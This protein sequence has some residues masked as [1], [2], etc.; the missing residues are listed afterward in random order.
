M[1]KGILYCLLYGLSLGVSGS[2]IHEQGHDTAIELSLL[3]TALFTTLFF[4]VVDYRNCVKNHKV[5]YSH[6][7]PWAVMSLTIVTGWLATYYAFLFSSP[8]FLLSM[9]FL[10][11]ALLGCIQ[12]QEWRKCIFVSGAI[13][14]CTVFEPSVSWLTASI[15]ISSGVSGYIYMLYSK[16]LANSAG[17]NTQGL[18]SIR[19]YLLIIVCLLVFKFHQPSSSV[20][21]S[22]KDVGFLALVSLLNMIIPLYFSQSAIQLLGA[23][24]TSK[25][26]TFTPLIAFGVDS[27]LNREFNIGMFASCLLVA[28]VLN[29]NFQVSRLPVESK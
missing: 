2:L 5:I 19:F 3:Y 4:N 7:W 27:V 1:N 12:G 9:L 6:F 24:I 22:L 20:L 28:V 26:L 10:T 14:A 17:L 23:K 8:H 15:A 18:L 25:Y 29:S 16:K 11:M 21:L 13:V